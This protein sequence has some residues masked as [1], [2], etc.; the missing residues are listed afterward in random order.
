[1]EYLDG[2]TPDEACSPRQPAKLRDAW[3]T[4]LFEFMLRGL[5]EC[6]FL[7]ADPNLANFAFLEDGRVV[8]YDFGCMKQVTEELAHGYAE[9]FLASL[10]GRS[11]AIPG[12]LQKMGVHTQDGLPLSHD[13]VDP[14]SALFSEI[15]REDPPYTFGEDEELYEK[16]MTLG[17][18]NWSQAID[19]RF[20]EDIVFIDRTLG[21]HF[22]NLSRLR[23]QGPWRELVRAYASSL[24][25]GSTQRV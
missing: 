3:G 15:L 18:S 4:V 10:E 9:V 19:I 11:D 24:T 16:L 21:G 13:L 6:R 8:V 20:P 17:M 14:Y 7:H 2:L 25:S 22:G 23:A 12:A 5:L 1:M